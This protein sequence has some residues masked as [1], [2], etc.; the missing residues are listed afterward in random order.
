[1]SK[2]KN[3]LLGLISGAA[4]GTVLGLLYAPDKGSNLR[5]KLSYQLNY[6]LEE[7]TDL[8]ERLNQEKSIISDAKKQGDLVVEDAREKAESLINEAEDLLEAINRAKESQ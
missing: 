6:Y 8:I 1:M 2:G 5:D 3:Y 7:L 4:L